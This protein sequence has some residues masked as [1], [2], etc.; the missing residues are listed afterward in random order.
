MYMR[1]RSRK[2][3]LDPRGRDEDSRERG[4]EKG[5]RV[6]R[7]NRGGKRDDNTLLSV[8]FHHTISFDA[9]LDNINSTIHKAHSGVLNVHFKC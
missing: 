2:G 4:G 3:T 1:S 7:G 8:G 6:G 9:S 5:G